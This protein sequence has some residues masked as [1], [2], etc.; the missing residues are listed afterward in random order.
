MPRPASHLFIV[1]IEVEMKDIDSLD[2]QMPM[3]SP[4]RYAVFDFAKNIQEFQAQ[5]LNCSVRPE[6]PSSLKLPDDICAVYA[7]GQSDVAGTTR[8]LQ[9]LI[10]SYKVFGNDLS[11][12]FS[13]LD[14]RHATF[15]GG[16]IFM[17]IAG[18]KPDPV[19][20]TIEPPPGWRIVNG[21]TERPDQREWQ[22]PNWDVMIDA[23]T[24][25]APD[26]TDDQFEVAGKKYHVVVH[27]LAKKAGS[28]LPWS[29]ISKKS[30]GR[31]RRCGGRRSL[32]PYTFLIHFAADDHS[33]MAWSTSPRPRS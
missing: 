2:F 4:G 30:F 21:W 20:L 31:K 10:V 28:A 14:T 27:S 17:Y 7:A 6:A 12:T 15:N 26:W 29:A 1:W 9:K 11:G 23:P 19:K 8:G 13:Q 32:M 33:V 5:T 18:H 3:W 16:S 24:E 25:I 22:Y